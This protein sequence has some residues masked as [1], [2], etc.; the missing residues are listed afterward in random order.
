M[1][2]RD[3]MLKVIDGGEEDE[4]KVLF[5]RLKVAFKKDP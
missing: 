3:E 2:S 1:K 4:E 5:E